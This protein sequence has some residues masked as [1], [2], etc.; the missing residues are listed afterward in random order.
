MGV[1]QL[2][3]RGGGLALLRGW[4]SA[5]DLVD[6]AR[7]RREPLLPPRRLSFRYGGGDFRAQAELLKNG[8]I[9]AGLTPVMRV[10]D[11]GCGIGRFALPLIDYI[12]ASKGGSY[13]GFDIIQAGIVWCQ[14]TITVKHPHF[15]FTHVDL[16][17]RQYNPRGKLDA[18]TFRFPYADGSFDF[19]LLSSVF[20]H[21]LPDQV[22]HYLAE[23][24]RTTAPG[25]RTY[26]TWFLRTPESL[27]GIAAGSARLDIRH[28][29]GR[30][31]VMDRDSPE[32][33][34]AFDEEWVME[35]Y[36]RH[37]FRVVPTIRY[38]KWSGRPDWHSF[39]DVVIAERV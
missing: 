38:G 12:D 33:A 28:D 3:P 39:Q 18:R 14:D 22:E 29:Q 6:W 36:S 10:L 9:G 32:K 21:M 26:I 27:A 16:F 4:Y 7:G 35:Q 19:V 20:T 25:A 17:N 31:A 5:C 34:I 1:K 2:V 23:I 24:A 8:A 11:V 13:D 15:R 37:G 30:F